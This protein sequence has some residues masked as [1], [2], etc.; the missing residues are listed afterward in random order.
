M[1]AEAARP[2]LDLRGRERS[3]DPLTEAGTLPLTP[4]SLG[5]SGAWPTLTHCGAGRPHPGQQGQGP[6]SVLLCPGP[7]DS[8][9]HCCHQVWVLSG[10]EGGEISSW[11]KCRRQQWPRPN[12]G[13]HRRPSK[14]LTPQPTLRE[15]VIRAQ[16]SHVVTRLFLRLTQ[17]GSLHGPFHQPPA[18]RLSQGLQGAWP[19]ST[20]ESPQHALGPPALSK[21]GG[22]EAGTSPS[23][24]LGG[25]G[26][27]SLPSPSTYPSTRH[28]SHTCHMITEAAIFRY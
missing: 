20:A 6:S 16:V 13:A 21:A 19:R 9:R 26:H 5:L 14:A 22:W 24:G 11:G 8:S 10:R 4:H 3:R 15:D 25:A 7:W 28:P 18:Q 2:S 1:G 23:P 17:D 27:Q 12:Q